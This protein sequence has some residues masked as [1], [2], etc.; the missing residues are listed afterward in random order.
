MRFLL[1]LLSLLSLLL[2]VSVVANAATHINSGSF[3]SFP[4]DA[5]YS[6]TVNLR[7]GEG[8]TNSLNPPIFSWSYGTNLLTSIADLT[9]WEFQVEVSTNSGFSHHLV[10]KRTLSNME[11]RFA[12]ITNANGTPFA[13][14][15]YWKVHYVGTNGLTN[16]TSVTN[17]FYL[18]ATATNWDRS[19][20]TNET[21]LT[22]THPYILLTA[23]TRTNAFTFTQTNRPSDYATFIVRRDNA[24][25]A[26]WWTN[27]AAWDTNYTG[28]WPTT[29][30]F[31]LD[32]DISIRMASFGPVLTYFAMTNDAG[33]L[34]NLLSNYNRFVQWFI[35]VHLEFQDFG[36]GDMPWSVN[37]LALGFDWLY[38]HLSTPN[39]TNAIF[40]AQRVARF[41]N[42]NAMWTQPT[43]NGQWIFDYSGGY[44][45][46]RLA[47][48]P[49]TPK[50]GTSHQNIDS[51]AIGTLALAFYQEGG[52]VRE[53]F[54]QWLNWT[55]ARGHF[56]GGFEAIN[57]GRGYSSL[58]FP[59]FSHLWTIANYGNVF[60]ELQFHRIP[61]LNGFGDWFS[62]MLPPGFWQM[63]DPWGD[64]AVG[65]D[66]WA[67]PK[68]GRDLALF[69]QDGDTWLHYTN[70]VALSPAY[71][72]EI[73]WYEM[74]QSYY[75]WPPPAP[76]TNTS[77]KLFNED[78]WVIASSKPA[79]AIDAFTNGVG[80]VFCARPRGTEGGHSLNCDGAFE[81]WA[82]GTK[83]NEGGGWNLVTYAYYPDSQDSLLV[84]GY[85]EQ[86]NETYTLYG[87]QPALPYYA[88]ITA[89]TNHS[90]FTYCAGDLSGCFTNTYAVNTKGNTRTVT[91]E[92]LFPH[93]KYFALYDTFRTQT[94][95]T[96]QWVWH[97][98]LDTVASA[99][100]TGFRYTATN[101]L[102]IHIT[103]HV[104]HSVSGLSFTNM[105]GTNVLRNPVTGVWRSDSSDPNR[106]QDVMWYSNGTPTTNFSFLSVIVPQQP[107][108][109]APSFTRISD[110]TV[111][112]VYDGVTDVI[113][114]GRT[115]S[116]PASTY[117]V[118]LAASGGGEEGG[119]GGVAGTVNT[120]NL[121][122]GQIQRLP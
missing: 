105:T 109:S 33:Y 56:T 87:T 35:G 44:T 51:A 119:G 26:T 96:F 12:P 30:A 69:T 63:H 46:P 52:D 91:R 89:Y 78:G 99:S 97:V 41:Y 7:P 71:S 23:A 20:M 73:Y 16:F 27:A 39:K 77:A 2:M 28:A 18:S 59:Q 70:Q 22:K 114:F 61:W 67:N 43:N 55:I 11:N 8:T 100:A 106:N 101:R 110:D 90:D 14:P 115:N 81:P 62:R 98:L 29:P 10:S 82:Y 107:G 64:G 57:Q 15:I 36:Y 79:N 9:F 112:V 21:Y 5:A 86:V 45:S 32:P 103:N 40:A 102:G 50:L 60:P 49:N 122:V 75:I 66:T 121:N 72:G 80:F 113:S 4:A 47:T 120:I 74:A 58:T 117:V 42:R 54:D 92:V 34:P 31:A 83:L 93:R 1:S 111:Q 25:N 116:S 3:V 53:L 24:T 48:A 85:G 38:P 88:R 19:M 84:D 13:G 118:N 17:T 76:T 6:G 108:V 68:L 104:F 94:N 65:A 95:A 37:N